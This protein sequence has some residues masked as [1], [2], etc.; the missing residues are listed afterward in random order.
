MFYSFIVQALC[1]HVT[2]VCFPY[3]ECI[4]YLI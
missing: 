2:M 1:D 4:M 3:F